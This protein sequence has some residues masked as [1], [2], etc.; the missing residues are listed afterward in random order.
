MLSFETYQQGLSEGRLLCARCQACGRRYLPPQAVCPDCGGGL[1]AEEVEKRG[2]IRT[3]TVIRVPPE[4]MEAPYIVAMVELSCGAW[5]LGNLTGVSAD[6]AGMDLIGGS[7]AVDSRVVPA[8]KYA[9]GD[10]RV[11]SFT[12]DQ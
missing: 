4:G 10:L 3:F 6:A 7:V 12:L 1:S 9:A 8:D 5:A 11:L 2:T